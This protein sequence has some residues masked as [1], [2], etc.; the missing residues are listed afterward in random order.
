MDRIINFYNRI[1]KQ[2]APHLVWA[3][4]ACLVVV[5]AMIFMLPEAMA[6]APT[7]VTWDGVDNG[8]GTYLYKLSGITSQDSVAQIL[9]KEDATYIIDG[10]GTSKD[11]PAQN[12]YVQI[13]YNDAVGT[14]TNPANVNVVLKNV[15]M[16]RNYDQ[17][18]I[19]F[20]TKSNVVDFHVTVEG[21]CNFTS[22]IFGMSVSPV[23][24]VEDIQYSLMLL[25]PPTTIPKTVNDYVTSADTIR[26]I[27]LYLEGENSESALNVTVTDTEAYGAVIGSCE[28]GAMKA[29]IDKFSNEDMTDLLKR[30]NDELYQQHLPQINISNPEILQAVIDLGFVTKVGEKNTFVPQYIFGGANACGAGKIIVGGEN[31]EAPLRLSIANNGYG[32]SIGGGAGSQASFE[33][34]WDASV[35]QADRIVMNALAQKIKINAGT[36]YITSS[37]TPADAI[38]TG[39][40]V[41]SSGQKTEAR[42]VSG[43]EI[44]G[45]SVFISSAGS[46]FSTAPVNKAGEKVYLVKADTSNNADGKQ[47]LNLQNLVIDDKIPLEY[48]YEEG[49]EFAGDLSSDN[50]TKSVV[51]KNIAG[52]DSS[53]NVIDV[54]INL[55]AKY[56][57]KG[58]GHKSDNMLYFYLPA[59]E[60]TNLTITDEFGPGSG[61]SYA[62]YVVT[63]ESGNIIMPLSADPT[64]NNSRKYVLIRGKKYY[65]AATA[66]K[67]LELKKV[68]LNKGAGTIVPENIV[69]KGY[70]VE[71]DV[72]AVM[73]TFNYGGNI[74]IIYGAGF[75][76]GDEDNHDI[77]GVLPREDY[78]YGTSVLTLPQLGTLMKPKNKNIKDLIF[79]G[80]QYVKEDGT[81]GPITHITKSEAEVVTDGYVP[82]TDIIWN[83]GT[84]HIEATWKIEVAFSLDANATM[85]VKPQTIEVPYGGGTDYKTSV[86]IPTE[87][88]SKLG[89]AFS[90]WYLDDGTWASGTMSLSTLTSHKFTSAFVRDGF[91]VYIDA[92]KL[93]TDYAEFYCVSSSNEA[94]QLLETDGDGVPKVIDVNGVKYYRTVELH[95]GDPVKILIK[96]V[97][98]YIIKDISIKADTTKCS[99]DI[100]ELKKEMN[101]GNYYVDFTMAKEDVYVKLEVSIAAQEYYILFRDG[102]SP[103][104][105][106]WKEFSFHYTLQDIENGTTIGDIIRRGMGKTG[107]ELSDTDIANLVNNIDKNDR[108][109]TFAG[110]RNDFITGIYGSNLTIQEV[111]ENNTSITGNLIFTAAWNE[112]GKVRLNL[113]VMER[114][115][116]S[117]D[118][119]EDNESKKYKGKLYY[120]LPDGT[121]T[122]VHTEL[123][124]DPVTGETVE[125][126]YASPEDTLHIDLYETDEAGNMVGEPVNESLDIVQLYYWYKSIRGEDGYINVHTEPLTSFNVEDEVANGTNIDVY[127]VYAVKSYQII[128]WNLYGHDNSMNPTSFTIYDEIDFIP[129]VEGVDW[130]LVCQDTDISN[131]DEVKT[132]VITGID[133]G[134]KPRTDGVAGQ[135][136]YISNIVLMPDWGKPPV[137]EEKEYTITIIVDSEE[138]GTVTITQPVDKT[139]YRAEQL[140][141]LSALAKE[142]YEL[143]PESLVYKKDNSRVTYGLI[144]GMALKNG[145]LDTFPLQEID[146][147]TGKYLFTMPDSDVIVYAS[148]KLRE[149]NIIYENMDVD[150]L[151]PNPTT[152]NMTS[153]I[154]LK[155]IA[156]E[157]YTFE[158]WYDV[159][160]NKVENIVNRI[161]D[162]ILIPKFE[163]I[164]VEPEPPTEEPTEPPTE[165]PTE[166]PT[167][168]PEPPTEEPTE[169]PTQGSIET[170]PVT[171]V[172]RPSNL[173]VNGGIYTP[174][175]TGDKTDIPR[176]VLI[177]VAAVLLLLIVIIKKPR[178]DEEELEENVTEVNVDDKSENSDDNQV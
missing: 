139:T 168:E 102:K 17:S 66:P 86:T 12:I 99:T 161:G 95:S 84:I 178:N 85:S 32:A 49:L 174:V 140:I 130:L 21:E 117:D 90:G 75:I 129:I 100:G 127:I 163:L 16:S 65:V 63:D 68:T 79:A 110:W 18:L 46:Y 35:S 53:K 61:D 62:S 9:A 141:L 47:L 143:V 171:I 155:D 103:N 177:C 38:G 40:I 116:L 136:D 42:P 137:E 50:V 125:I 23:I 76:K 19:S 83:D 59:T 157:G 93:D 105:Q 107:N 135:R 73:M 11:N 82:Y 22:N 56:S 122:P 119:Y 148:F 109:T 158:G 31:G 138:Y 123:E 78:V 57:Y 25:K 121:K 124:T 153:D 164:P 1:K 55:L 114:R 133:V 48:L 20:E 51:V 128:Y 29:R 30:L 98:G 37:R 5:V 145:E 131:F 15:N 72:G 70:V 8:D 28:A 147:A 89:Y 113:T 132:E 134:G 115:F 60:N 156:K 80:W 151:N 96:T 176:L 4:S 26:R 41:A 13:I 172:G 146:K 101:T 2:G 54:N 152:Y 165:E 81:K 87:K 142:G 77:T 10:S 14:E 69:S 43:I 170:K 44:N 108:F 167:E 112:R 74:D 175:K 58:S 173:T 7:A 149:Y 91:R 104:E 144:K 150:I 94:N 97:S 162:I 166:P 27:S 126:A 45:G 169:P 120:L 160:G 52:D 88:P 154:T 111:L 3:L 36:V 6:G 71:T 33:A 67:N 118:K 34:T 64:D 24:A 159:D 106:L 92:S 39:A